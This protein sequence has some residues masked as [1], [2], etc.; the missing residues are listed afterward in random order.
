[1]D[2]T[3]LHHCPAPPSAGS[4]SA[5]V[6]RRRSVAQMRIRGILLWLPQ[7]FANTLD[8]LAPTRDEPLYLH[9]IH[10]RVR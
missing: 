4:C 5:G 6:P 3:V 10:V 9:A 8:D 1:M 2:T 7:G